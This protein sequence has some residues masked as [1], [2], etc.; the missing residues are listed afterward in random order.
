MRLLKRL[1]KRKRATV[2]NL[3]E[4]AA[5]TLDLEKGE[6]GKNDAGKSSKGAEKKLQ[7]G[8]HQEKFVD[9]S[10]P[11]RPIRDSEAPRTH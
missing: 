6:T 4:E 1:E 11:E 7:K 5:E 9:P 10:D 8:R 2:M 3:R